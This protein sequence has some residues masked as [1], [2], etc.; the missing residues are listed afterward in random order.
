[1]ALTP[2]RDIEGWLACPVCGGTLLPA[3][4][5]YR[6]RGALAHSFP[7]VAGTPVLVDFERSILS[8]DAISAAGLASV[9]PRRLAGRRGLRRALAVLTATGSTDAVA[10]RTLAAVRRTSDRPVVVVVGGGTAGP[11]SQMLYDAPD[12]R[13]VSFD[14]Y[15]SAT[16]QFIA[17]A[18]AI[19]LQDG[20][21]DAVWVQAVL[22]HVLDPAQVVAEIHRVL[23]PGGYVCSEIPFMQQV[24]EGRYDFTRFSDLGQR[25]LFRRFEEVESGVVAGPVIALAWSID[26][27]VRGLTRVRTLGRLFGVTT[28][29]FAWIERL[30]P[31]RHRR[32]AASCLYFV[33]R[34]VERSITTSELLERYRGAQ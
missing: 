17:D 33:G 10:H 4:G 18:H 2:M 16:T 1:M 28:S 7:S 31:E 3:E 15:R 24:H 22:E 25:W 14:I 8:R 32:D 30:M 27:V 23:K 9:V 6:C 29:L 19:P 12:V 34:R 5:G 26:H 21:A 11:G 13:A 20:I